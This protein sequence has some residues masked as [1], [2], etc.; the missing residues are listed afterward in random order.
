VR[1][2][3]EESCPGDPVALWLQAEKGDLMRKVTRVEVLDGYG[4]D[5]T[6][7]DRARGA[8]D[9]SHLAGRGVFAMWLDR[10]AF[11]AVR[12]G[13]S[14]ELAWGDE[15]DL[16]PDALYLRM[17]GKKVGDVFPG[18]QHQAAHA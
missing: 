9:L 18:A 8:V 13:S 5:L 1:K 10:S 2:Q 7:D 15:I 4:L 6:F 12:I 3:R 14:G 17:T 11:E 16:C